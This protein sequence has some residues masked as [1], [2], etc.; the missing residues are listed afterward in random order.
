MQLEKKRYRHCTVSEREQTVPPSA[1]GLL[2]VYAVLWVYIV[3]Y[4]V[5]LHCR[6]S[7]LWVYKTWS[8]SWYGTWALWSGSKRVVNFPW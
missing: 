2:A 3:G 8:T 4:A 5:D 1:S 6:R 7:A